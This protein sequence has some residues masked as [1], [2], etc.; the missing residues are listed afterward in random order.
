MKKN[1]TLLAIAIVTIG[2]FIWSNKAQKDNFTYFENTEIFCLTNGHQSLADHIHP[3]LSITVD[4][5]PESIPANIG[6]D[7]NCMSEIHTH[8]GSGTIH[9]ESF[10][11]E[12][13]NNFNLGDFFTV[14]EED[15]SRDGYDLEIMQ[16]GEP[17]NS[18]EDVRFADRSNIELRYTTANPE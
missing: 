10:L 6:I 7:R 13:V 3:K 18:I 12:R 17:K 16:D 5:E 9:A 15:A 2:L 8:D 4:G 1:I 11:S 14:W